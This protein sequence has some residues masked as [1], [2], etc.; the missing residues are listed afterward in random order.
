MPDLL[1]RFA[2][3]E[4]LYPTS[5]VSAHRLESVAEAL[6]EIQRVWDAGVL[7]Y[8]RKV[9]FRPEHDLPDLPFFHRLITAW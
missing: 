4:N 7:N 2:R 8:M 1:A 9:Y 5:A 6:L 3:T